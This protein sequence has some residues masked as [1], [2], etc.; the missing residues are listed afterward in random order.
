M[1]PDCTSWRI[2][3]LFWGVGNLDLVPSLTSGGGGAYGAVEA[4]SG[5]EEI[6]DPSGLDLDLAVELIS[7]LRLTFL[8]RHGTDPLAL[9]FAG[10]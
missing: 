9:N 8:L 2:N 4:G 7:Q 1:M 3:P 5:L 10:W 6:T